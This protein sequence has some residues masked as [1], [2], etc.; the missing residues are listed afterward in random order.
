MKKYVAISLV[1]LAAAGLIDA[2]VRPSGP[3]V[4]LEVLDQLKEGMTKDEVREM[5]GPPTKVWPHGDWYYSRFLR[6]GYVN[7]DFD[8]N[9]VFLGYEY[10]EY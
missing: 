10:E 2:A 5:V 7:I 1:V 8:D 4:P 3:P 6:F 9:G